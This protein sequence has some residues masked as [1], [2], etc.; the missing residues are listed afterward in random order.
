[1]V[2]TIYSYTILILIIYK[3]KKE[4]N[5]NSKYITPTLKN[6][7]NDMK[8]KCINNNKSNYE[9]VD[10]SGHK[11]QCKNHGLPLE[12]FRELLVL[13]DFKDPLVNVHLNMTKKTKDLFHQIAI[14]QYMSI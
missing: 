9:N 12:K 7:I 4:N 11:N 2:Y 10:I 14:I 13:Q 5:K 6:P 3:L 1:M 8:D